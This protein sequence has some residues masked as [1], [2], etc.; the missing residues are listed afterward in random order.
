MNFHLSDNYQF[1][2]IWNKGSRLWRFC[3]RMLVS[4]AICHLI[5]VRKKAVQLRWENWSRCS[6]LVF[7]RP[8]VRIPLHSWSIFNIYIVIRCLKRPE[9]NKKAG[10]CPFYIK[11]YRANAR[12][13]HVILWHPFSARPTSERWHEGKHVPS[14]HDLQHCSKGPRY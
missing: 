7:E 9:I 4:Q 10:D 12:Q 11:H 8:W 6:G 5:N 2:R 3:W 1:N 14:S 13:K